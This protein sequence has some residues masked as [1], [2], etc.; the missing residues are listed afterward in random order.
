MKNA[1]PIYKFRKGFIQDDVEFRIDIEFGL[2]YE[3]NGEY[4]IEIFF[5]EKL[6]LQ[7]IFDDNNEKFIDGSLS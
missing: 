2:V 1:S 7:K 4:I 3:I 5:N 6:P